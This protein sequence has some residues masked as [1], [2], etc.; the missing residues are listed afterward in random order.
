MRMYMIWMLLGWGCSTTTVDTGFE[1]QLDEPLLEPDSGVMDDSGHSE[2]SAVEDLS[3]ALELIGK[4]EDVFG[5]SHHVTETSWQ[6]PTG[7]FHIQVYSNDEGRLIALNDANNSFNANKYSV[8]EWLESDGQKFVSK[9]FGGRD[10]RGCWVDQGGSKQFGKMDV[11]VRDGRDIVQGFHSGQYLDQSSLPV[12]I[13]SFRWIQD[14]IRIMWWISL[15]KNLE[16]WLEMIKQCIFP[17]SM[18]SVGL[19][20]QWERHVDLFGRFWCRVL[21]SSQCSRCWYRNPTAG[22]NGGAWTQ[23]MV[24]LRQRTEGR[25]SDPHQKERSVTLV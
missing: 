20:S 4:W 5:D 21:G 23:L 18:E 6:N 2:D 13:N 15:M 17:K 8:F 24:Q 1:L 12:Q 11:V 16:W 10:N 7:I 14:W 9:W 3:D 19:D 22:C 25:T